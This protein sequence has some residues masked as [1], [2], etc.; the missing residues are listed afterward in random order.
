MNSSRGSTQIN[1]KAYVTEGLKKKEEEKER[2]ERMKYAVMET[3]AKFV[4]KG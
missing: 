1:T 2:L 3:E 4:S